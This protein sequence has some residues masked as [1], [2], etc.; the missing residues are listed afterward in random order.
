MPTGLGWGRARGA[1]IRMGFSKGGFVLFK[2]DLSK[3]GVV[4]GIAI[5]RWC[6]T[7]DS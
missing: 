4:V 2:E 7:I 5:G 3:E 1:S 6:E